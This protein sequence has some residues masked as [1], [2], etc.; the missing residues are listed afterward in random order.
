MLLNLIALGRAG[1]LPDLA[2]LEQEWAGRQ[3]QPTGQT[4]GDVKDQVVAEVPIL[5]GG[6]ARAGI[7]LAPV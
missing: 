6:R 2:D 3:E 1:A 7:G 5:A 4:V